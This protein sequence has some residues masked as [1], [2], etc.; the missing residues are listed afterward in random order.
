MVG[1]GES[2][3]LRFEPLKYNAGQIELQRHRLTCIA[4]PLKYV[5]ISIYLLVLLY[6]SAED[7]L[8]NETSGTPLRIYPVLSSAQLWHRAGSA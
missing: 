4:D 5:D 6:S 2:D 3:A 7:E 1:V 8:V